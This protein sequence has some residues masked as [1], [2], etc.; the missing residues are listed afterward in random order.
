MN[1][2]AIGQDIVND[3]LIKIVDMGEQFIPSPGG[4]S[5]RHK[6]FKIIESDQSR[7]L[8]SKNSNNTSDDDDKNKGLKVKRFKFVN[9]SQTTM[10]KPKSRMKPTFKVD[11]QFLS[12]EQSSLNSE[13]VKRQ[14]N[15]NLLGVNTASKY[16]PLATPSSS[17]AGAPS[18]GEK[19]FIFQTSIKR[20]PGR[21]RKYP[22]AQDVKI[23]K[24]QGRPRKLPI[25][26]ESGVGTEL[27]LGLEDD[28]DDINSNDDLKKQ[29]LLEN[30]IQVLIPTSYARAKF[31]MKIKIQVRAIILAITIM[32]ITTKLI[33]I[34]T[35]L[36]KVNI[37]I[38]KTI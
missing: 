25:D 2:L 11:Q 27:D 13:R 33:S 3:D 5:N 36:G 31:Y 1:S 12:N 4:D 10:V 15:L 18:S 38:W 21:P 6:K 28:E 9:N 16:R 14:H 17:S 30:N 8:A 37:R 7:Q 29:L 26:S 19:E 35:I 34:S 24:K 22:A 20:A 23:K 32:I